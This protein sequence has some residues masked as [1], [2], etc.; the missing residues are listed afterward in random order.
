MIY[1]SRIMASAFSHALAAIA[2]GQVYTARRMPWR[3]WALSAAC[4]I[5]PDADVVGFAFGIGYGDLLGHRGLTHSLVFALA[6]G[7][8]VALLAFKDSR[9]FSGE[10][11]S[12]ALYFAV[13]T[14]SHG[15]FD[16]MTNGGLGVAFFAPF[17]QTRYFLPWRPI[18]VSPIGIASF[19]SDWGLRV[20]MSEMVWVWLPSGLLITAVWL[21]RKLFAAK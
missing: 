18:E 6:T 15:F 14:A 10:W 7:L 5:L 17:D 3:F 2:L 21:Y 1:D 16:A 9:L 11:W 13:V 12:L 4:A 8:T 20:I 19:F